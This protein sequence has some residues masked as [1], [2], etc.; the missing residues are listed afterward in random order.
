MPKITT[1]Y[2]CGDKVNLN[3]I[4]GKIT[5]VFIRGK[6]RAYEFSYINQGDPKACNVEECELSL[7]KPKKLGF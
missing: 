2:K 4:H 3:G 6:G 7:E 1:K 5:A